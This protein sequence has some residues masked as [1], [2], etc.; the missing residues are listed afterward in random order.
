MDDTFIQALQAA[1]NPEDK[2]ALIA[3]AILST[4]SNEVAHVARQCVLFHWFDQ[5]IVERLLQVAPVNT[6]SVQDAYKQITSLPFIEQL[7]WGVAYQDLTRQGLLRYYTQTQP[8]LLKIAA[9]IAAPLYRAATESDRHTFE[10][11][12]CSIISGD[13]TS[14][15]YLNAL[16]EQA[17]SRQDW[18][19]MESLLHL[20]EEAEQLSFTE[21]LPRIEHYWMLRSIVDRVQGRFDEAISD[22]DRTIALN[23]N[24]ALAYLNRSILLIQQQHYKQGITDYHEAFR[25]DPSLVQIYINR[26]VVPPLHEHSTNIAGLISSGQSYDSIEDIIH[27]IENTPHLKT[28]IQKDDQAKYPGEEVYYNQKLPITNYPD[29]QFA[30]GRLESKL[31]GKPPERRNI[32][33]RTTLILSI[34]T[35]VFL[36]TTVLT[37]TH[38]STSTTPKTGIVSTAVPT[39]SIQPTTTAA[40]TSA[41]TPSPTPVASGSLTPVSNGFIQKNITLACNGCN[42]PIRVTITTIQI[43]TAKGRMIWNTSL[44]DVNGSNSSYTIQEYAL[45]DSVFRTN[46]PAVL[47]QE[48]MNGAFKQYD[49]QGI[50]AFVPFRNVIYT[51]TVV[52]DFSGVLITFDPI[53]ITF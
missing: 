19:Q 40:A 26:G 17:M 36:A 50:F 43:D 49:I 20:Q 41:S 31:T 24:N 38:L 7:P 28:A 18:Q 8:D 34:T 52:I 25:L 1:Q 21:P 6:E 37:F 53:R 15:L 45:Q 35:I 12:F 2:A 23:S 46:V 22:Y 32:W 27:T 3:E 11:L 33:K 42:D 13:A 48:S 9:H 30:L 16:L 4:F 29:P 39:Q 10:A 44:T 51:L 14:H 5:S 47:S